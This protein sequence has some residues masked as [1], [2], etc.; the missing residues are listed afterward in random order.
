MAGVTT[1]FQTG[2]HGSRPAASSGC[3]LYSCTTHGLVYR[4]DGSSWATWLTLG[5]S[6]AASVPITDAGG[7]FTGTDVEAAL[8]ELGAAGGGGGITQSYL[9]K[10][11]IGATAFAFTNDRTYAKKITVPSGGRWLMSIDFYIKQN[12]AANAGNFGAGIW[13]DVSGKPRLNIAYLDDSRSL[14]LYRVSGTAGDARWYSIGLGGIFLAAGDYWIGV[15][16]TVQGTVYNGYKDG[17][18]TD[19]YWDAGGNTFV[20]DGPD[21]SGTVYLLNVTT[22]DYSIRASMA[23]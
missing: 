2:V 19:V 10:N 17:S 8:Q 5:T 23:A 9:G 15:K 11:A 14:N 16:P 12:T 1:A 13:T 7:Y 21:T 20:T 3:V 4:S 6:G 18:G 22:D